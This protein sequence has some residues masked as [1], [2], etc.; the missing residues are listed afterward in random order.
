MQ[1]THPFLITSRLMAGVR[2]GTD[3]ISIGYAKRPGDEGRTRYEFWIDGDRSGYHSDDLQSSCCGGGIREGMES[4]LSFLVASGESYAYQTRTGSPSDNDDLFPA[5]VAE[6]AYQNS[7]E[8]SALQY[9]IEE[10]PDC[11]VEA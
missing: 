3:T 7:D 10:T 1:L 11:V 2:V 9:E 5:A 8:L 6:W 4:L